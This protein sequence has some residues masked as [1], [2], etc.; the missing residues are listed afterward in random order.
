MTPKTPKTLAD[1]NS[2]RYTEYMAV[3]P[4]PPVVS[5][6]E[7]LNSSY[8]PDLEYVDGA[9]VERGMPTIAHSVLQMILVEQFGKY[10][11]ALGYL[12]LPEVRTRIVERARYR[13]PDVMLCPLPIPDGKVVTS[14][15]WAIVEILS[16]DD[17]IADQLARFQDYKRIGVAHVVLLDPEDLIAF[18]FDDDGSLLRTQFTSL[19]LPSGSLPFDTAA[20]FKQ[21]VEERNEGRS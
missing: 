20:L 11:K 10:R 2:E 3:G 19:D 16:P 13:I 15:P 6:D 7:Y 4:L 5:A 21:L 9:L 12:P 1:T 8:R 17:R 18:R 14:V